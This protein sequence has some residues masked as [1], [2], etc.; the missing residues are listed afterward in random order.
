MTN[1]EYRVISFQE[2]TLTLKLQIIPASQY[3]A[4]YGKRD[5]F[6]KF[7]LFNVN[8]ASLM[9]DRCYNMLLRSKQKLAR[10]FKIRGYKD[11]RTFTSIGQSG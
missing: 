1:G 3:W 6:T 5:V 4:A 11:K 2:G 7:T 9:G 8:S 10:P